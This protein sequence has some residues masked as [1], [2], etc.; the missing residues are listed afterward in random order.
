MHSLCKARHAT[1]CIDFINNL[2]YQ[3]EKNPDTDAEET[4]DNAEGQ[5]SQKQVCK[6]FTFF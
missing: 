4:L 2:L 5:S 1:T 3:Q 6:V